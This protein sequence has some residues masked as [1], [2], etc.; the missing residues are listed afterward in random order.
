MKFYSLLEKCLTLLKDGDY[1][2]AI[3]KL[4]EAVK[5]NA[6]YAD[7]YLSWNSKIELT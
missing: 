4:D 6:D 3:K 1:G 7:L 2:S 5:L